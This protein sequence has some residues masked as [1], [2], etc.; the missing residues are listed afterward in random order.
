MRVQKHYSTKHT[1]LHIPGGHYDIHIVNNDGEE[2]HSVAMMC[3]DPE[4]HKFISQL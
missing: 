1:N 2:D 4:D 3:E